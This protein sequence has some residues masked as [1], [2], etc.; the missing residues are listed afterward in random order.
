MWLLQQRPVCSSFL[1]SQVQQNNHHTQVSPDP[2]YSCLQGSCWAS[3]MRHTCVVAFA[4]G[5]SATAR[6]QKAHRAGDGLLYS[7]T[8]LSMCWRAVLVPWTIR[9]R[10][11]CCMLV[12]AH[13][14]FGALVPQV[15]EVNR[16]WCC[17][18]HAAHGLLVV[19]CAHASAHI[20]CMQSLSWHAHLGATHWHTLQLQLAAQRQV[21]VVAGPAAVQRLHGSHCGHCSVWSFWCWL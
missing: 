10:T 2:A 4:K 9:Q 20:K 16:C 15:C 1:M 3:C 12:A 5:A 13:S 21:M 6:S 19:C 18:H 11:C 14:W 7:V 17:V 8:A